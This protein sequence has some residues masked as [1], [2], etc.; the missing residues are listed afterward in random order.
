MSGGFWFNATATAAIAEAQGQ[1][2]SSALDSLGSLAG[3][4]ATSDGAAAS[5]GGLSRFWFDLHFDWIDIVCVVDEKR[6]R[7]AAPRD[8][9][10]THSTFL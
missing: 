10:V 6:Q 5:V 8:A 2:R 9:R 7:I 3:N 4:V 1:L